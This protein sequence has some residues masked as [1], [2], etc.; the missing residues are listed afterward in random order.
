MADN[1]CNYLKHLIHSV[2]L[3]YAMFKWYVHLYSK[4]SCLFK[5]GP[6]VF[7][8]HPFN[9]FNYYQGIQGVKPR[10]LAIIQRVVYFS[11]EEHWAAPIVVV[12]S[13][14]FEQLRAINFTTDTTTIKLVINQINVYL[15]CIHFTLPKQ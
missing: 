3:V 12:E 5:S 1:S 6:Q 7:N 13:N 9:Y 4:S 8:D 14:R 10:Q 15:S 11:V 2:P